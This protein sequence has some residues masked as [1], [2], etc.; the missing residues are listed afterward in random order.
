MAVPPPD[1]GP[2]PA[3]V[4]GGQAND[5]GCD[6][7]LV[8]E[9]EE[10]TGTLPSMTL[11]AGLNTL[12]GSVSDVCVEFT[13]PNPASGGANRQ[14]R[15]QFVEEHSQLKQALGISASASFKTGLYKGE[16]SSNF[17]STAEQTSDSA[18]LL[19]EVRVDFQPVS[20]PTATIKASAL[21]RI[22][23][24]PA[25]FV[26]QC[27]DRYIASIT[28][29]GL[30]RAL[31]RFSGMSQRSRQEL[32]T[33]LS[34][35]GPNWTA[36]ASF[37]SAIERASSRYQTDVFVIQ[38]GGSLQPVAVTP[39]DLIAQAR[40]FGTVSDAGVGLTFANATPVSVSTRSYYA[41]S[42]FPSGAR[43]PTPER[44]L[45]VLSELGPVYDLARVARA[46]IDARLRR[47]G[48]LD[49]PSCSGDRQRLVSQRDA[50]NSWIREADTVA[51]ACRVLS[52]CGPSANCKGPSTMPPSELPRLSDPV[53]CG[54]ACTDGN[55]S[56]YESDSR[57]YC[58]R[59]TF[60]A[61]SAQP[62]VINEAPGVLP[63]ACKYMRPGADVVVRATGQVAIPSNTGQ[64]GDALFWLQMTSGANVARACMQMAG[65]ACAFSDSSTAWGTT[66]RPF[67]LTDNIYVGGDVNVSL[68][69]Y[70]CYGVGG[71]S[72]C[73]YRNVT[74]DVCDA[75]RP[76]GCN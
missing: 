39:S 56:T 25:G 9:S 11:G 73:D 43:Y 64:A 14:F 33:S 12:N 2:G 22:Q 10:Y 53:N 24:D 46:D 66:A 17:L 67:S 74:Y 15:L 52:A 34:A 60:A 8:V 42:N 19:L 55:G 45:R 49:T 47:P 28:S 3:G 29:G 32:S 72:T 20:I 16:A 48:R 70:R 63:A 6:L 44:Q 75:D 54:P 57:G 38:Q 76:A 59:C 27:G 40:A 23:S 62:G 51:D 50:I 30:F 71:A 36:S 21:A 58:T 69:Q 4:D 5:A 65:N 68:Y 26:A 31:Y 1:A 13:P 35:G 7:P 61:R 41:A 18:F 37:Q